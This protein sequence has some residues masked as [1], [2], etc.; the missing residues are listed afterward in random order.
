MT[1]RF[2]IDDILK[3][4]KQVFDD[5]D[6]QPTQ[7]LYL[8]AMVFNR[9]NKLSFDKIDTGLH[10]TQFF[11]IPV[12]IDANHKDRRYIELPAEIFDLDNEKAV[13]YITYNEETCG[14]CDG[15]QFAQQEFEPTTI[16]KA[17]GL[18]RSVY[19]KPLRYRVYLS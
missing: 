18:Y 11:P 17:K 14:C 6:L 19:S 1:Y 8:A 5:K 9:L 4:F 13:R 15:P 16:T 3:S 12:Q 2:F 7:V 10:V